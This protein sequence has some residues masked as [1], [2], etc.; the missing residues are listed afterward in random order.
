MVLAEVTLSTGTNKS[1]WSLLVFGSVF[2]SGDGPRN[3]G[4]LAENQS[5]KD[6]SLKWS[7]TKRR[8]AFWHGEMSKLGKV[9]IINK[10]FCHS[11]NAFLQF[12]F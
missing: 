2:L 1:C 4:T 8:K 9:R 5:E 6:S 3:Q 12:R 7:A 11:T 10:M